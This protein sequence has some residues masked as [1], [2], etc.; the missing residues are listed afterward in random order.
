MHENEA[1]VIK[2]ER[3]HDMKRVPRD[4]LYQTS[5]NLNHDES[6]LPTN[7]LLPV[8]WLLPLEALHNT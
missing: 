8:R 2:H 3:A 5:W 6:N 1:H 4:V 7:L